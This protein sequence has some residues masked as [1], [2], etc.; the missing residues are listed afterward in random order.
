MAVSARSAASRTFAVAPAVPAPT[1]PATS[2]LDGVVLAVRDLERKLFGISAIGSTTITGKPIS[3]V[4][5]ADGSRAVV[6]TDSAVTVIDTRTEHQV[7][8]TLALPGGGR[9][10]KTA[11][12]ADGSRA[13]VTAPGAGNSVTGVAVIDTAMGTQVGSTLSLPGTGLRMVLSTDG[14][15]AVV[16]TGG[17]YDP[18]T[19]GYS[20]TGVAVIDTVTGNQVGSTVS[21]PGA[22]LGTMLSVDGSRA[23]VIT[24][25]YDSTTY[26]YSATRVA[27]VDTGTG[28]QVGDPIAFAGKGFSALSPDGSRVVVT[29]TVYNPAN[30]AY[31]APQVAV[32]E[33]ASGEQVGNT[34]TI[35]VSGSSSMSTVFNA[36][37]S[38]AVTSV[39][40]TVAV[41]D[42]TTGAQVGYTVAFA[43]TDSEVLTST[44]VTADGSRAIV[45]AR[46]N[47][48]TSSDPWTY[49]DSWS[50]QV[51]V[52][53]TATGT[54]VGITLAV[55]GSGYVGE[56]NSTL[57]TA[58]GSRA[59]VAV[60]NDA[61]GYKMTVLVV[62]TATGQQIG[63]LFTL[64][65][66][67]RTAAVSAD[68]S[69]AVVVTNL[70]AAVIDAATGQQVGDM[71]TGNNLTAVLTADGSR[72]VVTANQHDFVGVTSWVA[73]LDTATGRQIGPTV[74]LPSDSTDFS[75]VLNAN[76]SRALIS[77]YTIESSH[78]NDTMRLVVIDTATGRQVGSTRDITG[79]V[80]SGG[81]VNAPDLFL[82]PDGTRALI[83]TVPVAPLVEILQGF[84]GLAIFV[85]ILYPV[86]L[87]VLLV[88]NL[89][90]GFFSSE[91]WTVI[92]TVKGTQ[93]GNPHSLVGLDGTDIAAAPP[94]AFTSDGSGAL[95]LATTNWGLP[96]LG[97]AST[98]VVTLP[99]A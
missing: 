99:T 43:A 72:A 11:L 88:A 90:T 3:R 32:I 30:N 98:L 82:S 63:T 40:R 27:V 45:N 86:A 96:G 14:S 5:T 94:P 93:I 41:V 74:N 20:A 12:T 92:D 26:S 42:T 66:Q 57:L 28:K 69:R 25:D 52:I 73:V 80:L 97:R 36:D 71:L 64:A 9:D 95:V 78:R 38:R 84:V 15:R 61:G 13:V 53:D 55:P 67:A 6:T 89:L 56:L 29:T 51:A 19:Y 79:R 31:S 21:L 7:G 77:A 1:S 37:G 87:P 50:S 81:D 58:D 70:Y 44:V 10:A 8:T 16:I 65:G 60:G 62:D 91:Q 68:G 4:L 54:Q 85:P 23:V 34:I 59:I 2:L 24:G 18:T 35:G 17:A 49:Q 76:G 83:R 75:T 33:T 39:G 48:S 22:S 46:V 47:E